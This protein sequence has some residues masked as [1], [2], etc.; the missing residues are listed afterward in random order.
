M[1]EFPKKLVVPAIESAYGTVK[2]PGS[3]S[4]SNRALVLAALAQGTTQLKGILR[5]DD[6]E[7]MMESLLRL[8]V[9]IDIDGDTVTVRG[10]GG[11]F[12]EK[13]VDLF[14]GNAGTAARTLTA[15]LAFSGGCFG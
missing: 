15:V 5:A 3:K 8:G 10:C 2:L 14:I 4:I 7:R 1:K 6:T 12:P 11:L 9:G 13:R